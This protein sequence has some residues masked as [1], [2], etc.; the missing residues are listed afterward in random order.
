MK[1]L[2]KNTY[3]QGWI[4]W[5]LNGLINHRI[6]I[7]NKD[8]IIIKLAALIRLSNS[9]LSNALGEANE[10]LESRLIFY[11]GIPANIASYFQS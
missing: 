8:T 9:L 3:F 2:G 11:P 6:T 7:N 1:F 5:I 4:I 10:E